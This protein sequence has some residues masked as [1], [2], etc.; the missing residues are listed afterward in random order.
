MGRGEQSSSILQSESCSTHLTFIPL[1]AVAVW[2]KACVYGCSLVGI[3]GSNHAGDM[4][5]CLL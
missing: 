2:S 4:D 3:A 1:I 5:V